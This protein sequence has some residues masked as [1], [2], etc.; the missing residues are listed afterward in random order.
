[1][2]K[3]ISSTVHSNGSI[4]KRMLKIL[5]YFHYIHNHNDELR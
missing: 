5:D 2:F 1:M 3:N 4:V